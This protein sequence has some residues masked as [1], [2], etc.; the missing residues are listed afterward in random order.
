MT[1]LRKDLPNGRTAR[2]TPPTLLRTDMDQDDLDAYS[3][4]LNRFIA[5]LSKVD[6]EMSAEGLRLVHPDLQRFSVQRR[7]RG[8]VFHAD[9]ND[10]WR[11]FGVTDERVPREEA[12][13]DAGSLL[14]I[15]RTWKRDLSLPS[16]RTWPGLRFEDDP[17][18]E[19]A[20]SMA[21]LVA[22]LMPDE[23]RAW[24]SLHPP[25][26][27]APGRVEIKTDRKWEF[28]PVLEARLM[29][30]V[31][32]CAIVVASDLYNDITF[33]EEGSGVSTMVNQDVDT[34]ERLR[35][36]ASVADV[37]RPLRRL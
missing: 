9:V 37:K 32:V 33:V 19:H 21:R 15:M 3:K 17:L 36:L 11:A 31:P 22:T 1:T 4:R 27:R 26:A 23:R 18:H 29:K 16:I 10:H 14:K 35:L 12:P 20:R 34:M 2:R 28:D 30:E 7:E 25:T 13:Q 24:L 8:L 5:V 6:P